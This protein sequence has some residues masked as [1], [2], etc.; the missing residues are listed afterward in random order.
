MYLAYV[1]GND[2]VKGLLWQIGIRDLWN[3]FS[4]TVGLWK[5]FRFDKNAVAPTTII[6]IIGALCLCATAGYSLL[7]EALVF[8]GL[9]GNA[10]G[11]LGHFWDS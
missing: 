1:N 4:K 11:K 2:L 7:P 8:T 6:T 3:S 5:E 9:P 10:G